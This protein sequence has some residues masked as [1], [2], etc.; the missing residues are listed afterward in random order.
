MDLLK[1][2]TDVHGARLDHVLGLGHSNA[3][4]FD[5]GLGLDLLDEHLGLARVEGNAGTT[6][7]CSRR[8]STPVDVGLG[9]LGRLDLDDQVDVG[10]VEAARCDISSDQDSELAFLEAL[11]G[12]FSLVLGDVAVHHLDVLL[13]LVRE[14]EGV[15]VGLRLGED[16][17]LATLAVDDEDVGQ[18]AEA[19]LVGALDGQVGDVARRLV[20]KLDG[21][22]DDAHVRLHV[23]GGDVAHPTGDGGREQQDLQV[24]T[25]LASALCKDLCR[26][27]PGQTLELNCRG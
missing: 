11:H 9:L 1:V 18:G 19:V 16:N 27:Q 12:H 14:E 6:G 5:A 2:V 25:A 20:L 17:D 3:L 4:K 26:Q 13:D 23:V 24:L 8:S 10:D 21:Q 15:G 7:S 22:V